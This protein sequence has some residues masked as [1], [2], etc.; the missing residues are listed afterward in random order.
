MGAAVGLTSCPRVQT[1][2]LRTTPAAGAPLTQSRTG[3]S[4]STSTRR[5]AGTGAARRAG[6]APAPVAGAR[7]GDA[8][9]PLASRPARP[10]PGY[11][12]ETAR[13]EAGPGQGQKRPGHTKGKP[14]ALCA[15]GEANPSHVQRRSQC[16][17]ELK[18][19]EQRQRHRREHPLILPLLLAALLLALGTPQGTQGALTEMGVRGDEGE[20]LSPPL[21]LQ[22]ES[23]RRSRSSSPDQQEQGGGHKRTCKGLQQGG[24][25]GAGQGYTTGGARRSLKLR[26]GVTGGKAAANQTAK[27]VVL[28]RWPRVRV[29]TAGGVSDFGWV[30]T[31]GKGALRAMVYQRTC[32]YLTALTRMGK[33]F[34]NGAKQRAFFVAHVTGGVISLAADVTYNGSRSSHR[35]CYTAPSTGT[36]SLDVR[37]VF[38]NTAAVVRSI[39]NDAFTGYARYTRVMLSRLRVSGPKDFNI[40]VHRRRLPLCTPGG[41]TATQNRG[42]WMRSTW[43]PVGCRLKRLEPS[44]VLQCMDKKR[45]FMLGDSQTRITFGVLQRYLNAPSRVEFM[46]KLKNSIYFVGD[47]L[48]ARMTE[49]NV[50]QTSGGTRPPINKAT[51]LTYETKF[52]FMEGVPTTYYG[53]LYHGFAFQRVRTSVPV[54][55]RKGPNGGLRKASVSVDFNLTYSTYFDVRDPIFRPW[56]LEGDLT[57]GVLVTAGGAPVDLLFNA[58]QLHDIRYFNRSLQFA[59]ALESNFLPSLRPLLRSVASLTM[60]GGM[61]SIESRLKKLLPSSA[62]PRIV[63]FENAAKKTL[64]KNKYPSFMKMQYITSPRPNWAYDSLHYIWPVSLAFIDLWLGPYCPQEARAL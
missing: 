14:K 35:V 49:N 43:M 50:P 46:S 4:T 17:G 60:W 30:K 40:W 56:Q 5:G 48:F 13:G 18:R 27:H 15:A 38:V 63:S 51:G 2:G 52:D 19:L 24:L 12:L 55:A 53:N 58:N 16:S 62:N 1:P 36:Y 32:F 34:D 25:Q 31:A 22:G 54:V 3:T 61:S 42:F 6:T 44:Q 45:V 7:T 64:K 47:F 11:A 33:K 39:S 9:P 10:A 28:R 29:V 59:G 26:K 41:L 57:G 21:L 23:L 8:A 37:I 20:A